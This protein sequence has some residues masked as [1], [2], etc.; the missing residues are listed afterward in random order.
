MKLPTG[1][2]NIIKS[3]YLIQ[4]NI[5]KLGLTKGL[6][7]DSNV[8][9]VS[10]KTRT[11]RHLKDMYCSISFC[12]FKALLSLDCYVPRI[13]RIILFFPGPL[14]GDEWTNSNMSLHFSDSVNLNCK[15]AYIISTPHLS[16]K[17]LTPYFIWFWIIPIP[18][19][20]TWK[21]KYLFLS[22]Q[23][24]FPVPLH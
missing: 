6:P 13:E 18:Y 22:L 4:L 14:W 11:P 15:S 9:F 1:L 7:W 5:N 16:I 21:L 10:T 23:A 2:F 8:K 17:L 24:R 19:K 20:V 12:R 3:H